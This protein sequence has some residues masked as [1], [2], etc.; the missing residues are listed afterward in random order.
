MPSGSESRGPDKN[1]GAKSAKAIKAAKKKSGGAKVKGGASAPRN[2]PWLTIGAG[3]AVLALVAVLAINLV[4]KYQAKEEAAKY[5][6][7]AENPDPS[8]NI[9]AS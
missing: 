9:D 8:V 6:P 4:P 2:I 5:A 7:S 1:S 3:A